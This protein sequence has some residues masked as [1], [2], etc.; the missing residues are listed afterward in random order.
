MTDRKLYYA[1]I[2][3]RAT[4]QLN[5]IEMTI[6]SA[7]LEADKFILRSGGAKG[8]DSAFERGV[9]DHMK[10]IFTA[11][12]CSF[13]AEIY[14]EK[15]HPNWTACSPYVRRLMGRNAHVLFGE[16][17]DTPVEFVL[18]W[19]PQGKITGGT[20]H[21]LRMAMEARIP[22]Y[23]FGSDGWEAF[24]KERNFYINVENRYEP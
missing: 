15:Y 2:G 12:D 11:E 20:G 7:A 6:A 16:M 1:G 4:P 5:L 18:C 23:N 13:A 24:T 19:T 17:L 10:D 3:A 21:T 8:A 22:I 14:A 9:K